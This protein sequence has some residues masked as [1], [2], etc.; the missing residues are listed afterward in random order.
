M[1]SGYPISIGDLTDLV[2][3]ETLILPDVER[4]FNWERRKVVDLVAALYR[5]RPTGSVVLWANFPEPSEE[6]GRRI[7]PM[8]RVSGAV[9]RI[10]QI[11]VPEHPCYVVLDGQ[12][13][14]IALYRLLRR[15]P[16][17]RIRFHLETEAFEL[18]TSLTRNDPLWVDVADVIGFDDGPTRAFAD[19]QRRLNLGMGD[20]KATAY[21]HTLRRLS[22]VRK[23]AFHG[24]VLVTENY[25]E[26]SETI[27]RVNPHGGSRHGT[28]LAVARLSF[29]WPR[30]LT[31]AFQ[32]ALEDLERRHFALNAPFLMRALTGVAQRHVSLAEMDWVASVPEHELASLW[33]RT[34]QGLKRTCEFLA[35]VAGFDSSGMIPH[36]AVLFPM[37]A[38][39]AKNVDLSSRE[40]G[41]LHHWFVRSLA[42]GRYARAAESLVQRDL[43]A[44]STDQPVEGLVH[45]MDAH[46]KE[47]PVTAERFEEAG[48]W[49]PLFAA[50]FVVAQRQDAADWFTGRPLRETRPVGRRR[51]GACHIFAPEHFGDTNIAGSKLNEIANIAFLE[52]S[53]ERIVTRE[54]PDAYFPRVL[55]ERGEEAL[56]RQFVPLDPGLWHVHRFDDF[57]AARRELLASAVQLYIDGLASPPAT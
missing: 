9:S 41:L 48:V 7:R 22:Q 51:I 4:P 16:A 35:Q 30:P 34:D 53:A 52:R 38:L 14:L 42:L 33:H 12:K 31:D 57:L 54:S 46:V 49:N 56:E 26:V 28:E 21:S 44:L 36:V 17:V 27:E 8:A 47:E 20:P 3:S 11:F 50:A 10:S 24:E 13:R 2:A 5:K 39:F 23:H 37:I 29:P 43:Y 40:Q 6:G 45:V 25:D 18:E 15:D 55:A 19:V 32:A 1:P